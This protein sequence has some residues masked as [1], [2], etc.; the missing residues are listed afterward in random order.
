MYV[1]KKIMDKVAEAE[2]NNKNFY[3]CIDA[4]ICPKCGHF[5][6][7]HMTKDENLPDEVFECTG[8]TCEFKHTR[9]WA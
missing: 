2:E 4:Q 1:G 6:N 3:R 8:R 5:L 7:R 9:A